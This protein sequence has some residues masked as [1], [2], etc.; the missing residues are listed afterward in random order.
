[1]VAR[2]GNYPTTVKLQ[3]WQKYGR[4]FVRK[5]SNNKNLKLGDGKEV[6]NK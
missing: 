2:E 4:G 5:G 3:R 6:Q 1:L